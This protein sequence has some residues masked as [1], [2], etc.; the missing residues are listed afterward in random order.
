MAASMLPGRAHQQCRH[1]GDNHLEP[2]PEPPVCLL[3]VGG[4]DAE[5]NAAAFGGIDN[6]LD[7]G[8]DLGMAELAAISHRLVKIGRADKEHVESRSLEQ[9]VEVGQGVDMLELDD[10]ENPVV[11]RRHQLGHRPAL[12]VVERAAAGQP[13]QTGRGVPHRLDRRATRAPAYWSA[14][15]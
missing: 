5:R 3:R 2:L 6:L 13:A 4:H 8:L 11:D 7:H 15:S 9:G 10:A 14:E 12:A 1:V